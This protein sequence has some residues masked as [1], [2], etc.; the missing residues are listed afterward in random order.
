MKRKIICLILTI[1][2]CTGLIGC[3][4]SD[5]KSDD[6]GSTRKIDNSDIYE[7]VDQDTGVHYLVYSHETDYGGMGG[8]TPRLKSDGTVMITK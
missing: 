2:I 6:S 1:F 5:V 4:I 3:R 8:M 7:F